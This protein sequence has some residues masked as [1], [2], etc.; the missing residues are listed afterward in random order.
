[1]P[2]KILQEIDFVQNVFLFMISMIKV[3]IHVVK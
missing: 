1:M 2:V 3:E